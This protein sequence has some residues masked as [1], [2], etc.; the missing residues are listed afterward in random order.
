MWKWEGNQDNRWKGHL[1]SCFVMDLKLLLPKTGWFL[2]FRGLLWSQ[3]TYII[4]DEE[5]IMIPAPVFSLRALGTQ[6]QWEPTGCAWIQLSCS[7]PAASGLGIPSSVLCAACYTVFD[8][9][10]TL[11]ISK[12]YPFSPILLSIITQLG[13]GISTA[14][15]RG[16]NSCL[17][18]ADGLPR[19]RNKRIDGL[20]KH[21]SC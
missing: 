14:W 5:G 12:T 17:I 19:P 7:H 10:P 6:M 16:G 13:L 18:P 3:W 8:V 4:I 20:S 21:L 15:C 11:N 1:Q 2:A 9:K